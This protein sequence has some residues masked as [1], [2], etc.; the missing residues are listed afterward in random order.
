MHLMYTASFSKDVSDLT[1]VREVTDL[2]TMRG[3]LYILDA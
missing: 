3:I 1:I 2:C